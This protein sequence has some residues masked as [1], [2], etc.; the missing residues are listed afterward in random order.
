[1]ASGTL[2][3]RMLGLVRAALL[4]GVIGTTGYAADGFTAANSLPNTFYLLIAGGAVNAIFVPQIVRAKLRPDGDEFVNRI[5]TISLAILAVATVL[6]TLLAPLAVRLYYNVDNEEALGLATVFAVICLPQI[7]FYGL[8]TIL[9]QV[10]NAHGRFAG[11]MW[12][13]ALANVVAIAGLVWFQR[14]GFPTSA[15]PADWT[16]EMVA[17]LAGSA[18]LSIV[19]QALSLLVP[20]RRIGFR[21]R[22]VWGIRGH[23]LGEVSSVAKW[24]FGSIVVSSL[25]YVVTSRV[26]TRATTLGEAA[27]IP[28]AGLAA[29]NPALLIAM[30]LHGLFVGVLAPYVAAT[31]FFNNP[32]EET[33]AIA[34]VL[35]GLI[36]LVIPMAWTYLN[37][38]V[39]YAHQMT[40]MTF[41]LQC[42]STGL[43]TVGALVAATTVPDLTAF[44][45]S[46]GQA[47][48]YL[49]TASI[50]FFVLRRRH[51]PLG[52]R[53]TGV[54]YLKLG[55]PAVVTALALYA[56]IHALL[57]D[58]GETRGVR[59]FLSGI[60]VLGVAGVIELAVTWGVAS[61]LGVREIGAALEPVTRRLRRH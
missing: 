12:A 55:V 51:G 27:G 4:T 6:V 1:M 43:A 46:V 20:L 18:T 48:A 36:W 57:P 39:F 24:T 60:V 23:G 10:L 25:G 3:S 26:L 32:L 9:G 37:D 42:V 40:W 53:G 11:Y 19:V 29:F 5:I 54:M 50:G 33:R 30:L 47:T 45:L 2:V 22:P 7:F 34:V 17:I 31:L 14:A 58:L 52:L 16:P 28:V 13:P 15:A 8:Y 44:T 56:G 49:V 59:G 21:Y 41:R 35:A 38:R 61:A